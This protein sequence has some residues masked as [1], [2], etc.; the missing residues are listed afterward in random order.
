MALLQGADAESDS[1]GETQ[2]TATKAVRRPKK[3]IRGGQA[4]GH[5]FRR[6]VAAGLGHAGY[7]T[8]LNRV[9]RR[10]H[11]RQVTW[12]AGGSAHPDFTPGSVQHNAMRQNGVTA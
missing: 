10:K 5:G 2:P 1:V 12:A 7:A 11:S 9:S 8:P 6:M 3:A 4:T